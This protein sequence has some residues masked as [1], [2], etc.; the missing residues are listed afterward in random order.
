METMGP[1]ALLT[2]FEK[3]AVAIR[4]AVLPITG[5]DRRARTERPGQYSIDL[6]ADRVALDILGPMPVTVVSEESGITGP[7]DGAITVVIDPIDGSSNAARQI[8]Y[9]AT[10]LC[11]LDRDG[12]FVALVVNHATGSTFRA[13][14]GGGATR[15]GLPLQPSAATRVEDSVVAISN[16]PG[17]M[18]AWKQFR[19]LGSCAL[20]LCDVAAGALDGYFDAGSV[21]APWDYLGGLLV[22]SEAGAG[23][24]DTEDRPLAIADPSAR[25]RLVAAGTPQLLRVLRAAAG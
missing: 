5:S 25:R 12:L 2:A 21:H 11:A 9:W 24:I 7:T 1:E 17:R 6:V 13:I 14:R 4:D 15:D 22:C 19:A 8:P 20:A 10:S 23:V 16:L 3:T 18:L